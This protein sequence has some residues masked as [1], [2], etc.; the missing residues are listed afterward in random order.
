[1]TWHPPV[2][3]QAVDNTGR[4]WQIHRAWPVKVT[5]DYELEVLAPGRTGVRAAHLRHGHFELVPRDDPG[6]PTLR[7]EARHGEIIVYRP[8]K[9]AVIRAEGRYIKVF[10]PGR[11]IVPAERIAQMDALLVGGTF[12]VPKIIRGAPDVL[13][14]STIPG[15]SLFEL[16]QDHTT[17]SD[18][19][20]A[21]VWQEWS[22][23]WIGQLSASDTPSRRKV[24]SALPTRSA[25]VEAVNL[26]LWV[27]R[28]L[29]Y[30]ENFPEASLQRDAVRAT[31][32]AVTENL[33]RTAPDPLVWAHG[34]LH[35][36]QIIGVEGRSPLGLLDFDEAA[37]AEAALDL[38][39]LDVHLELHVRMD[40]MTPARYL[41][42][43]QQVLAAAEELHVS[44]GRFHAYADAT[45]LRLACLYSFLPR[46]ASLAAGILDELAGARTDRACGR[47]CP[48]SM[49]DSRLESSD[50]SS[51]G[52]SHPCPDVPSWNPPRSGQDMPGGGEEP[53]PLLSAERD[54]RTGRG[55][56]HVLNT[57]GS[58]HHLDVCGMSRDPRHGDGRRRNVVASCELINHII[59]L[60][61]ALSIA[62]EN[63]VEEALLERRPRLQRDPVEP[64]IVE[65]AVVP[66]NG[67]GQAGHVG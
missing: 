17:V 26:W 1:M 58:E 46:R 24:M 49:K 9:R 22:R 61:V 62:K 42:A 37:Q 59:Q 31:A 33:L 45:R 25:G 12:T 34:D 11:A 27:E 4:T 57:R 53:V 67:L 28:W 39:N 47:R 7:A 43:H 5:G 36:K 48:V 65:D 18:D 66:V 19:S 15:R 2:P 14:F 21:R 64:A 3:P 13:V 16:G 10:R 52:A 51:P 35:D 54:I 41:A 29:R 20:F 6:L 63:T 30:S 32:D 44:P 55:L 60:G 8:N 23:A 40:R 50:G 38:A 56:T